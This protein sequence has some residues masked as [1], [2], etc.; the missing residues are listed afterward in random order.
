MDPASTTTAAAAAAFTAMYSM[1]GMPSPGSM[2]GCKVNARRGHA[3][4]RARPPG[5][6]P[7]PQQQQQQ[8]PDHRK[9]PRG[10]ELLYQQTKAAAAA[11][12]SS[13]TDP[14]PG[15]SSFDHYGIPWYS[16]TRPFWPYA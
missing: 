5:E 7:E 9:E 4:T 11:A 3:P 14:E 12:A 13:T 10:G 6:E 16:Q 15:R 8:R 1:E 2:G